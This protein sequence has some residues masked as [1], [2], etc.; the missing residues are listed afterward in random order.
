MEF[1]D[2]HNH[3][4]WD[5]DDGIPTK[6]DTITVLNQARREGIKTIVATPHFVPGNQT[7]E[8]IEQIN[9]R[10][11]E[12]VELAQT[13]NV[14]ILKGCELFMNHNF[15]DMV[16]AGMINSIQNTNY[17]LVEFD[18][19]KQLGTKL[20][21]EDYLYELAIRDYR[22]IIAHVE[23]YFPQKLDLERLKELHQEGYI[24]Q[25]NK[26]SLLGLHGKTIQKNA[27]KIIDHG[28][29]HIVASDCHRV[30]GRDISFRKVY[31]LLVHKYDERIAYQLCYK[32][33]LHVIRNENVENIQNRKKLLG[34]F[35][36]R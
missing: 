13:Y 1:I 3:L 16:D 2:L 9:H 5:V 33:P 14:T 26:S 32:N 35:K 8:D 19:R 15:L 4:T 36:R 24:F 27:F 6:E 25:I 23:R 10:I 7:K 12:L 20:H 30:K 31:D 11:N 18:V 28:L 22:V 17:I 34:L 29:A 21:V